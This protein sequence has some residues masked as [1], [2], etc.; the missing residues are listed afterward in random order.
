V[1][2]RRAPSRPRTSLPRTVQDRP[3]LAPGPLAPLRA[4]RSAPAASATRPHGRLIPY[5]AQS[6]VGSAVKFN[7]VYLTLAAPCLTVDGGAASDKRCSL[8]LAKSLNV[9]VEPGIYEVSLGRSRGGVFGAGT[10]CSGGPNTAALITRS[11]QV[12]NR[13]VKL[14][15]DME[16]TGKRWIPLFGLFLAPT[17]VLNADE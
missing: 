16:G 14:V 7:E 13:P 3:S 11:V 10:I 2:A 5:I 6:T 15:Y 12:G 4:P 8:G 9:D 1:S 17:P